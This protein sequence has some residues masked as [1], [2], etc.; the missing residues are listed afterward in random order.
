MSNVIKP[1]PRVFEGQSFAVLGLG[2][3]GLPAAVTLRTMGAAVVAWDDDAARRD[4]AHAA[5]VPLARPSEVDQLDALILSPG[6]PHDR[7]APHP[8]AAAM[9]A[10]GVAILS[11]AELLFRAVRAAGSA[12]RFAGITG[13]NGKS[14]TT[15]LL[16][17]IF[18][19]SGVPVAAG[20]NLGPASLALPLLPDDGIYVLEMS[21]YMLERIATMRFDAAIMLNLTHD[22]LDRHGSM[23]GYVAAKAAIFARQT[24]TD[25]AVIGIDDE[26]SRVLAGDI[27]TH[28]AR[29]IRIS[30]GHRA[31]FFADRRIL[32]D[33]FGPIADLSTAPAL[34]GTHNAQNA[35]AAAAVALA[36]GIERGRIA[37]ALASFAGLPHRQQRIATID[38]VDFIDD[39]KATNADAAARALDSFERV[40][41]IAGGI[42]KDGGIAG[43][44][45]WFDRIDHAVLIGRDAAMFAQTL[46]AH[47]VAHEIAGTLDRAVPLAFDRA[48]RHGI[49]TVLLSPAAA[50][51]DQFANYAE[52]GL[53][54][55]ALARSIPAR[56]IS[57]PAACS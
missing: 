10:R 23:A 41:W 2:Q 51:F 47:G 33:E 34:R 55:A 43:L 14:T 4:A 49:D 32:Q 36:L 35:A 44:A 17:H 48:R 16:A 12:A 18:A 39:S 27:A 31:D 13:T 30:G 20:G 40:V 9:R 46:A 19:T 1:W 53:Q 38:G 25:T 3:N 6:I 22:H 54:F 28:A 29:L 42:G 24:D 56:S 21:S 52:R 15:A 11:D 45:P 57:L 26:P 50:S 5:G 8:E 7:P 37:P